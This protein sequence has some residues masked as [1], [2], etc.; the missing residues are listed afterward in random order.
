MV[1]MLIMIAPMMIV[2]D[3]YGMTVM[4]LMISVTPPLH[5]RSRTRA[6]P[7]RNQ[8]SIAAQPGGRRHEPGFR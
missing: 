7:R 4:M 1:I 5:V 6:P 3:I 2:I 8:P